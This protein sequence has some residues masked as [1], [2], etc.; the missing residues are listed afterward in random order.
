MKFKPL[1]LLIAVAISSTLTAQ[2]CEIQGQDN[3]APPTPIETLKPGATFQSAGG[4]LNAFE[5]RLND[6]ESLADR[7]ADNIEV[8]NDNVNAL[9]TKVEAIAGPK[10]VT[11]SQASRG[12]LPPLLTRVKQAA[13][14]VQPVVSASANRPSAIH[15]NVGWSMPLSSTFPPTYNF[16]PSSV[17]TSVV[18]G[19]PTWIDTTPIETVTVT[20]FPALASPAPLPISNVFTYPAANTPTMIRPAATQA[21]QR[22]RRVLKP[23]CTYQNGR[24]VCPN[25]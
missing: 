8:L 11:V 21:A 10:K 2:P 19:S 12:A 9:A 18:T 23:A 3:Q 17:S 25:R 14:S 24:L 13:Q 4:Q 15:P 22:L 1:I 7:N 16:A 6:V 20:E 5:L